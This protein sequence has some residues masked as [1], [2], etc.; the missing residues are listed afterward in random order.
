MKIKFYSPNLK[1]F[2]NQREYIEEKLPK[3]AKYFD[4]IDDPASQVRVQL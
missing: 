3:L 1:I 2:S 4:K